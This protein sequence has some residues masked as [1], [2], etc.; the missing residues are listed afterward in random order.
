MIAVA[1]VTC[2]AGCGGRGGGPVA[3]PDP[4]WDDL[5]QAYGDTSGGWSGGD[6]AQA[7]RMPD[8][9]TTWFFADTD[10]GKVA[11]DGTRSPLTT[12]LAHNSALRYAHGALGG[13][14]ATRAGPGGYSFLGDYTWV[15]PPPG[16]P[17]ASYEL[18]NGDQVI[19]GGRVV[20]FYQLADRQF[21]PSQFPYKLVGAVL[22]SFAVGGHDVLTPL[23]GTPAGVADSADSDPVIWGAAVLREGGYLYIYGVRP[24]DATPFPLYL[25]RVPA[26]G[27]AAGLPWQYYASAP[28][29]G[30]G[31]VWSDSPDAAAPL[32]TGVS[33]G[34]SVTR[35][36]DTFVLLTNN[37]AAGPAA[38]DAVA[39]Y[40]ACPAGFSATSPRHVI[41]RPRLP[42]GYLAY[43]YRVVPEFSDGSHVLVSY[44]TDSV[45]VDASCLS[46]TYYDA[47]VYRPRFLD[48]SLPGIAGPSGPVTRPPA[49]SPAPTRIRPVVFEPLR[50]A[51]GGSGPA[52]GGAAGSAGGGASGSAG[53][54]AAVDGAAAPQCQPGSTP[55]TA[56]LLNLAG[57][58]AGSVSLS[59]QM[60]PAAMWQYSVTSCLAGTTNCAQRLVSGS[61]LTLRG[62][63]PGRTYQFQVAASKWVAG[64]LAAWSAP[65]LATIPAAP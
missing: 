30:T 12:G 14:E 54:G 61:R 45:R 48:V 3:V 16:Y 43:E 15:A 29:C 17:P 20:K 37:A 11:A 21:H 51:D 8:G 24:Y 33:A 2:L 52:G 60:A 59:W 65:V 4:A 6:G 57:V 62:L 63:L 19:D 42:A 26:G 64:A 22:E 28:S 53:G 7:L 41:Y 32:R 49:R 5:F 44:S 18:I 9:G 58:G 31:Q 55:A 56:P 47:S 13:L 1:A 50:A 25:A 27:L 10:L 38:S 40:A 46:E 39:Y 23:G 35:V 36:N 34:F